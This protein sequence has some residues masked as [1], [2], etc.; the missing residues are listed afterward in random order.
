MKEFIDEDVLPVSL[1]GTAPDPEHPI[2]PSQFY[3]QLQK[4]GEQ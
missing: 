1:G 2:V 4:G 3:K